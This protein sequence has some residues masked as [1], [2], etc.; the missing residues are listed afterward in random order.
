MK[1]EFINNLLGITESY[2]MPEKLLAILLSEKKDEFLKIVEENSEKKVDCFRD[3][4]QSEHGDRDKLKQDYTPD[5]ICELISQLAGNAEN[6]L[7]L[8]SGTGALT[9]GIINKQKKLKN[10]VCEELSSRAIP[11]L[12]CNL[13]LRGI[14]GEIREKDI[15]NNKTNNI[16]KLSNNGGYSNIEKVT[17]Y[18]EGCGYDLIIS[19]P[20]YSVSWE[21]PTPIEAISEK[22]FEGYE[23]P[24]KSKADYTFILEA[25]SRLS[26]NGKAFIILPHGVLFR[27]GAEGEIRRQLVENNII[28]SII[29]LANNLF[30]NTSIPVF[31]MGIKKQK[32]D[33][34]ILF[35][36]GSKLFIHSA[37]QNN[38]SGEHIK[39]IAEAYQQRKN[40][41][42]FASLVTQEQIKQN[43]YNLNIPRYVDTYEKPPPIDLKQ[44]V[45]DIVQID[46]DIKQINKSLT[47]MLEQLEGTSPEENENYKE[48]IKPFIEWLE[49]NI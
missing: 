19:N 8:C 7:D 23:I 2:K 16:Y 12:L 35:I 36:D 48:N 38:M 10:V 20:P 29:G 5:C 13:A 32:Q 44:L 14:E 33:N 22:R 1:A 26:E 41:D 40:V 43:D 49:S 34:K 30:L 11:V 6:V 28:D 45:N 39:K 4:F 21:P 25:I 3:Y 47:E 27:G 24:P 46:N 31:I 42:K 17:E 9:I 15:L 18:K 37:K